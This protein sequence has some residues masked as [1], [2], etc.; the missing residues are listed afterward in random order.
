MELFVI[1]KRI[2]FPNKEAPTNKR[3]KNYICLM[4]MSDDSYQIFLLYVWYGES[5]IFLS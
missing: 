4:S 1:A 5:N 3:N 2:F